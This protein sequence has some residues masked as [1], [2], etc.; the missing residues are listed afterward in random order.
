[1]TFNWLS[2]KPPA[3]SGLPP[4]EVQ[5][6]ISDWGVPQAGFRVD[7]EGSLVI[8]QAPA[9]FEDLFK[10][11][12]FLDQW[13]ELKESGTPVHVGEWGVYNQT[14]HDV[15]LRFMENRLMAMQSAGLGWALWNFR[16]QFGILDSGREDVEYK[17][18]HGH[19]LDRK[20]L[21][22]LLKH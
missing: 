13:I 1:M 16:G 8:Q 15:T 6:G 3:A 22:L 4:I 11:N 21:E 5:P 12:G 10:M 9:G 2:I 20:M 17:D 7:E 19:K 14:P 18:W